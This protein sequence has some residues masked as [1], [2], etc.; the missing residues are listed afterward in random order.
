MDRDRMREFMDQFM[1]MTTGAATLGLIGV[2]DRTGLFA[3]LAGQGP[4]TL[5]TI[6]ERTG[7]QERYLREILSGL[8]AAGRSSFPTSTRRASRTSRVPTSSGAGP[9]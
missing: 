2:G 3:S 7:L 6:V 4:L 8:A 9:R 1:K 5:D